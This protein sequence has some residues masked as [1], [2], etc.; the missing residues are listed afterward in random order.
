MMCNWLKKSDW[1]AKHY[2]REI[3]FKRKEP[4]AERMMRMDHDCFALLC[5]K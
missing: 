5:L 1:L 4:A 3:L 2:S